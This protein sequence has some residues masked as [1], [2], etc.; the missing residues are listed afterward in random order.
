[1]SETEQPIELPEA[2]VQQ[3]HARILR[4]GLARLAK[5][6]H[7]A[8]NEVVNTALLGYAKAVAPYCKCTDRAWVQKEGKQACLDCGRR[9][10]HAV[11]KLEG[12]LP[13]E[14]HPL[15]RD[16]GGDHEC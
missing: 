13:P 5:L 16:A 15:D 8:I 2:M 9:Y 11:P 10:P 6:G 14:P 1:M 3:K 12:G 4:E 7:P